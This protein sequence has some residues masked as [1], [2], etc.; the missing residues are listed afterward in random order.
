MGEEKGQLRKDLET[1]K[2]SQM[3]ITGQKNTTSEK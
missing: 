3:E 2:K 1:V